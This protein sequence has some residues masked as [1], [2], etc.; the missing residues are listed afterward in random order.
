[1]SKRKNWD[2][3]DEEAEAQATAIRSQRINLGDTAPKG[4]RHTSR[5][6]NRRTAVAN[7]FVLERKAELGII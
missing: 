5:A 6:R 3:F 1:M 7:S 4:G 2:R